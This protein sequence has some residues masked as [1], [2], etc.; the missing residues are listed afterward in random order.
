MPAI[1]PNP[2]LLGL[3]VALLT[4]TLVYGTKRLIVTRLTHYFA[5]TPS[6]WDD[7][8]VHA[9]GH[10]THIFMLALAVTVAMRFIPHDKKYNLY[11]YRTFFVI[12]MIQLAI[13]MNFIVDSIITNFINRKTRKNPAAASSISLIQLFSKFVILSVVI[14]FTLHNLGINITTILAGLGVGGIAVALAL[15]K[16]LRDLFSSLSIVMDKPFVVGDFIIMDQYLGEVEKIGL[17]TTRLRSLSGEQIIMSN[18][19]IL[20]TN[21]RN[22]KRM[23]ERRI[24]FQVGLPLSSEPHELQKAVSLITEAVKSKS[25]TRFDRCHFQAIGRSYLDIETVYYVLS[26]DYNVYMDIH[27]AILLELLTT[28]RENGLTFVYP[29]Q[30]IQIDPLEFSTHNLTQPADARSMS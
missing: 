6:K 9:L 17:R 12:S 29:A 25:G 5:R 27:Q 21:I 14:L 4:Y 28:F 19:E 3:G 7:I 26:P 18:S 13:W 10:T 1:F 23:K 24:V 15:Q 8:L 20:A 2:W 30:R 11:V 22:Y 16:I